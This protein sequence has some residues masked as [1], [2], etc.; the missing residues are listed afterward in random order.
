MTEIHDDAT[1]PQYEAVPA[2]AD[3]TEVVDHVPNPLHQ[4]GVIDTTGTGG[5][6]DLADIS[7]TFQQQHDALIGKSTATEDGDVVE[8]DETPAA[9]VQADD[10][11]PDQTAPD[12]TEPPA[13]DDMPEGAG[14]VGASGSADEAGTQAAGSE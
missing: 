5:P 2:E 14:G 11:D 7:P 3:E 13:Q 4:T 9:P 1:E 6:T 12:Q 10:V 8:A